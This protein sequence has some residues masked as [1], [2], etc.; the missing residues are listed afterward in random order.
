MTFLVICGGLVGVV[1]FGS[2]VSKG[3]V[4][5]F[6][7]VVCGL[8][9]LLY[10]GSWGFEIFAISVGLAGDTKDAILLLVTGPTLF[11]LASVLAFWWVRVAGALFVVMANAWAMAAIVVVTPHVWHGANF[12]AN[13]ADKV[14]HCF[15]P[16]ILP[17]SLPVLF[18]GM[19]FL[20]RSVDLGRIRRP[21]VRSGVGGILVVGAILVLVISVKIVAAWFDMYVG[22]A[23]K[24]GGSSPL[25]GR[26]CA[27]QRD[28]L[29]LHRLP[30]LDPVDG[31]QRR[32]FS[33]G[34]HAAKAHELAEESQSEGVVDEVVAEDAAS[35]KC[36]EVAVK[37]PYDG[38]DIAGILDGAGIAGGLL[39]DGIGSAGNGGSR[40]GHISLPCCLIVRRS[41]R[42]PP[43][44]EISVSAVASVA[45]PSRH[46]LSCIPPAAPPPEHLP[47]APD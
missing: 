39:L 44:P 14:L 43:E 17:V 38:D 29:I 8:A 35:M 16:V 22:R 11:L 42:C 7:P 21:W 3:G 31:A 9:I 40:R 13:L 37:C 28:H 4:G 15:L 10:I 27:L 47:W 5:W 23:A 24:Q 36:Q 18:L 41:H 20:V 25:L 2:V 34:R 6:R 46:P 19:W 12:G 33:V 30:L 32:H 26:W 1:V 45:L